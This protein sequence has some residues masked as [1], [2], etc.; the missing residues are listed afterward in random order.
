M[1]VPPFQG[2]VGIVNNAVPPALKRLG[3]QIGAVAQPVAVSMQEAM[4]PFGR[5]S[6]MAWARGQGVADVALY[7]D[8]GVVT[9]LPSRQWA[10]RNMVLYHGLAHGCGAWMTNADIDLHC[11]NSPYLA[12][13]LRALFA[14]P[15]WRN[16]R[17][18][19][20]HGLGRVTDLRL[21]L[22]CV[23]APDGSP[24]LGGMELPGTVQR[25]LE[26]AAVCGHALQ[27]RKQDWTATLSILFCLNE[28]A[29]AHASPPIKLLIPDTSLDPQRRATYDGFLAASGYSCADFFVA[30]PPLN[31]RALFRLMRASR[32]CLAYN[33]FPEPFGFYLLE[34]VYNGCPV[35]TNG[36]GN[37]RFLLPAEHGIE[38]R[39][40]AAM[41]G[42]AA[43]APEV[44]V[45]EAVAQE[46]YADLARPEQTAERCRRGRELIDRSWSMGAFEHSLS[47]ALERVHTPCTEP[48]FDDMQVAYSPLVRSLDLRTGQSLNDYGSGLL[49]PAQT[50]L[51]GQL[52]GKRCGD[53]DGAR[54]ARLELEHG[55]FRRGI[56]AL[57]AV[58]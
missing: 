16:R 38:V 54:M 28:L 2:S 13:V 29:R 12:R 8:A 17:C 11:A 1:G 18:L 14:C 50:E 6:A 33:A 52:L 19:N 5:A 56:L 7:D 48:D 47:A 43:G 30:V 27:P 21:P 45:F 53:L 51:I 57:E 20:T 4:L 37:N 34:S 36:V 24:H 35:Y 58:A 15:D 49:G 55:L 26:G 3:W 31:Q 41:A 25:Q 39:E 9:A 22:P 46:I 10:K 23:G 42:T 44:T 32:F 40:N